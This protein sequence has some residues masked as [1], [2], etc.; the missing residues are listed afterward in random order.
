MRDA[1]GAPQSVV[2]F[3]GTSELGLDIV[4]RLVANR[5]R[6]VVLVARDTEGAESHAARL[7]ETGA[8]VEVVGFEATDIDAH[9]AVADDVFERAGGTVDLAVVAVGQLGPRGEA[10]RAAA[11]ELQALN[12]GAVVSL[13][14]QSA[15]LMERQ[16]HGVLVLLS[17]VAAERPRPANYAYGASKATADFYARGLQTALEGSGVE[18][19]VVRPGFV[20]TRMTEGLRVPPGAV[21]PGVVTQAVIDGLRRRARIVY[22]PA[23]LRW[24]ALVLRALPAAVLRRLPF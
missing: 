1:T 3:G 21:E 20:R 6:S 11:A 17:S 10:Q 9:A 24:V 15:R 2:L 8:A 16:G 19:M 12:G 5:T 13:L 4:E 22:A 7:R 23:R 18:V 14:S